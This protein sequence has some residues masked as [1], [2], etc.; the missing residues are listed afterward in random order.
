[1]E[2]QDIRFWKRVVK[3]DC[4][5][6]SGATNQ[7][8]YGN[9]TRGNEPMRAHRYAW[10]LATGETLS[11]RDTICHTCDVP[12]CV[13]ND[14]VGEYR[15]G[16]RVYPRRGHLYKATQVVNVED[17]QTK[18]RG[19]W[20]RGD[21]HGSHR[22]PESLRRGER[23]AN[24]KLSDRDVQIIKASYTGKYGEVSAIARQFGVT[25]QAV[26][27]IVKKGGWAHI[28]KGNVSLPPD[29]L[30]RLPGLRGEGTS[31]AKLTD[32]QVRMLRAAYDSGSVTQADLMR[33]YGVSRTTVCLIVNRK[34]WKHL[35]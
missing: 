1:M 12:N 31:Q 5:L 18:N 25:S 11:S 17:R 21:D 29:Q 33:Q 3:G 14:D 32:E 16:H 15:L 26:S 10:E 8:G 6:W 19:R 22:H 13:R 9:L 27:A 24:S 34:I 28:S 7:D 2:N 35:P 4:W 23:H 20:A 30:K